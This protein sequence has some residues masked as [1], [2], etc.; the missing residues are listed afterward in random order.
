MMGV[1]FEMRRVRLL[2]LALAATVA[3]A[4]PASAAVTPID[5]GPGIKPSVVV[6]PAG[7]AHVL[8]PARPRRHASVLPAPARGDGV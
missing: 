7:T 4:A 3:G 6:D 5:L 8:L 1:C 2:L